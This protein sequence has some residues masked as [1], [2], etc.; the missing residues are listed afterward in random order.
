MHANHRA[1]ARFDEFGMNFF[2]SF[3]AAGDIK[4]DKLSDLSDTGRS[5]HLTSKGENEKEA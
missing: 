1:N 4:S 2:G 5:Y 3:S